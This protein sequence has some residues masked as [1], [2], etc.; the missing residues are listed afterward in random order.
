MSP[1]LVAF[2][3]HQVRRCKPPLELTEDTLKTMTMSGKRIK[4]PPKAK[5]YDSSAYLTAR[6]KYLKKNLQALEPTG[7]LD[8]VSATAIHRREES[9]Y[10][11]W[12]PIT[13]GKRVY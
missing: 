7:E 6:R 12:E 10:L 4:A 1:R 9:M 11:D 8:S 2:R 5:T 13:G 3:T